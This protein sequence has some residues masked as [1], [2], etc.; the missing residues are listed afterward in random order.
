[1]G[2][3]QYRLQRQAIKSEGSERALYYFRIGLRGNG[4]RKKSGELII[5]CP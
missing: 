1:M 4:F 5:I 2:H 3:Q